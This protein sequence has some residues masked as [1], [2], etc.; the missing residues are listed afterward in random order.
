VLRDPAP[1]AHVLN[2][3]D[4]GIELELGFWISDPEEGSQ[5]VR[6]D[7]SVAVLGE[8]RA[9]GIEIPVPQRD[10]RLFQ[11]KAENEPAGAGSHSG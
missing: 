4:N 6:S 10:V 1:T 11:S 5:N 2:L 9:L 8:F 7:I 3:A